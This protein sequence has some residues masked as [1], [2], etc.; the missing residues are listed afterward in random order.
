MGRD[1][2]QAKA[3]NISLVKNTILFLMGK[4][5]PYISE[6]GQKD[7]G[8]QFMDLL[9]PQSVLLVLVLLLLLDVR[10]ERSE[11]PRL[12]ALLG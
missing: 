5:E 4:D 7:H 2:L 1:E 9:L 6:I 8:D 10:R 11:G 3:A 12:P